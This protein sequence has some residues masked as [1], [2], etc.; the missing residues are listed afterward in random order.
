MSGKPA[1]RIQYAALPF[2]QRADATIEIMLI[3]SRDTGRWLIPKGWPE[4]GL[5]PPETAAHEAREEGGLVGRIADRS[6]GS[7]HYDKGLPDGS[8]MHCVVE[9]FALNVTRQMKSWPER[10]ERTTRWFA[11]HDAAKAVREPELRAIIRNLTI[12]FLGG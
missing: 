5:A 3:T 11:L 2:R 7:Y 8:T 10:D 9:V 12:Q 1:H 6:I 4:P